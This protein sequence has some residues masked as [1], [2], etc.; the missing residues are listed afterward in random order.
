MQGENKE[1]DDAVLLWRIQKLEEQMSQLTKD[2]GVLNKAM[3]M[4]IGAMTLVQVILP[5]IEKLSGG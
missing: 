2:V 3:Y 1:Y 5:I 4:M